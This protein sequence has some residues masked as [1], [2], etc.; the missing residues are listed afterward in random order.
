M[1]Q[2]EREQIVAFLREIGLVVEERMLTAETFLP[3]VTIEH[4]V[5]LYDPERLA[6]P[7]DLLHEAGHLAVVPSDE[8]EQLMANVGPD[9]GQELAAIA[10]SYAACLHLKLP[11]AVLFHPDGYKGES[12]WLAEIFTGG[13]DNM[14]GVPILTWR[15]L[16]DDYP[17]MKKW[18]TE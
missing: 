11:V 3:G 9:G 12:E 8:R 2:A 1:A 13:G 17:T 7:G 6:Y 16:T 10:W 15:G 4:G 18:L 14:M 5:I